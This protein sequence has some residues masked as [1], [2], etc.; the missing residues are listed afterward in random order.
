MPY[1]YGFQ[2]VREALRSRP[3]SV[4]RLLVAAR[5]GGR[6]RQLVA[7]CA[8]LSIPV[9]PARAGSLVALAGPHHQG[10]VAELKELAEPEERPGEKPAG[11]GDPD[12]V[13]LLE[14]VQDPRNLGAI[15]RVCEGAGVGRIL[16]RDR[17]SAP[18]S[19]TAVKASAGAA[20]W[21]AVERVV[22]SSQELDRL[23]ADGYWTYA[24]TAGGEPPWK[25]DLSG[26]VVVCFG[27]EEKGLRRRT[28]E[29]CDATI[30]LPM[31]GRI[32]SLNV[33]TAAAAVLFEIVRQ[34]TS[35]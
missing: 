19:P 16:I 28:I 31:Q 25:H 18:L 27:G 21:L 7:R 8:E 26:K 20:E 22:N 17:G 23:E 24:T 14:D 1:I 32:E 30:G 29:K 13:V 2:P 35:A 15:L 3:H 33:A 9:E 6:R 34:R 10:F 5:D 4:V 12:L 11:G